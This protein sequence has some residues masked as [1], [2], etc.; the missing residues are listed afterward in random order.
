MYSNSNCRDIDRIEFLEETLKGIQH[1]LEHQ[2]AEKYD[3]KGPFHQWVGRE[4]SILKSKIVEKDSYI[5]NI[6]KL[7]NNT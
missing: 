7:L 3:G 2:G 5:R 4:Y 6:G 1:L